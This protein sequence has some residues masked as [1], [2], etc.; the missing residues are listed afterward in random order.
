MKDL[1]FEAAMALRAAAHEMEVAA[2]LLENEVNPAEKM[3]SAL[4][5]SKYYQLQAAKNLSLLWQKGN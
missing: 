4:N 3:L 2:E 5:Q 1:A